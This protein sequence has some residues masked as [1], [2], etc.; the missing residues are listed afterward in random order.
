MFSINK[1]ENVNTKV[2][3][4]CGEFFGSVVFIELNISEKQF[5]D[6]YKGFIDWLY[7]VALYKFGGFAKQTD[8]PIC[9]NFNPKNMHEKESCIRNLCAY[10]L[11]VSKQEENKA[12]ALSILLLLEYANGYSS[13]EVIQMKFV[14]PVEKSLKNQVAFQL[15]QLL[16]Q[17]TYK[18]VGN[19]KLLFDLVEQLKGVNVHSGSIPEQKPL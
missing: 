3:V 6:D 15:E 17:I 8:L 16:S 11:F 19:L 2:K 18:N 12:Y 7:E 14:N 5:F 13:P 9:F 10:G 4:V 1:K